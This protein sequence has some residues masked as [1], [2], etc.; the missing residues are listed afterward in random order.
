[1]KDYN[2]HRI[3]GSNSSSVHKSWRSDS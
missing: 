1:M 2:I 3:Q